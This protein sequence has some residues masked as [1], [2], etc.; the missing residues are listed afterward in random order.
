MNQDAFITTFCDALQ[1]KQ[2]IHA[3][4]LLKNITEWDSLGKVVIATLIRSETGNMPSSV[5]LNQVTTV[6][7]L[8]RLLQA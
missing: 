6:G 8:F 2:Q 5:Q 4:T 7:E 3:E 1:V